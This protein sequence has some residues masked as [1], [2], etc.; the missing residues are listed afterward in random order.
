MLRLAK[1]STHNRK[2]PG[3][4]LVELL[5]VIGIIGILISVLLPAITSARRQAQLLQ[6]AANLRQITSAAWLHAQDHHGYLPLAGELVG[7]LKSGSVSA[8]FGDPLMQKYTYAGTRYY[9]VIVPLPAA[10]APYMGYKGLPFD[11][12]DKLDQ[13]LN[14]QHFWRRFQCPATGSFDKQKAN[15]NPNDSTPVGQGTMM[16]I[17]TPGTVASAWSTNSDFALNEGVLGY[18]GLY[19]VRRRL[20]GN[21]SRVHNTSQVVLFSDGKPRASPAYSWFADGWICWTP[22]LT[23]TGPVTLADALQNNGRALRADMFDLLR[24]KNR[25]NIAFADGHVQTMQINANDLQQAYLLPP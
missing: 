16:A 7:E 22:S 4:T 11:D 13:A 20:L 1:S 5:V 19:N 21:L 15:S 6:C 24:H 17:A 2:R 18:R 14:E 9:N 10:L 23:L 3:F 12:W 25:I 8:S